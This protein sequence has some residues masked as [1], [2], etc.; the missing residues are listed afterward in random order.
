MQCIILR[1][2]PVTR[3]YGGGGQSRSPFWRTPKESCKG[4]GSVTKNKHSTHTRLP[5]RH[6]HHRQDSSF[7]SSYTW[8]T[9]EADSLDDP[10]KHGNTLGRGVCLR[11]C[12]DYVKD[13]LLKV[14]KTK[15]KDRDKLQPA[16]ETQHCARA[17]GKQYSAED[18]D[19]TESP[20]YDS[21]WVV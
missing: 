7:L 14:F 11:R 1:H 21:V 19:G 10:D 4:L 15:P 18:G 5:R 3:D 9:Q 16:V 2:I 17:D 20:L 8:R 12:H 6:R 13:T